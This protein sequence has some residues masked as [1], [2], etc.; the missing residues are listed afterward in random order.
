MYLQVKR[1]FICNSLKLFSMPELGLLLRTVLKY[2]FQGLLG[3][4]SG[5]T[6]LLSQDIFN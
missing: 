1:K 4:L 5:Q 2:K 3:S 6:L